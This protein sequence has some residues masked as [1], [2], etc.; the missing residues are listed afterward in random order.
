MKLF[1][2]TIVAAAIAASVFLVAA[3]GVRKP[4]AAESAPA[5]GGPGPASNMQLPPEIADAI[6]RREQAELATIRERWMA[7]EDRTEIERELRELA[8]N[9]SRYGAW[10]AS[11]HE[12]QGNERAAFEAYRKYVDGPEYDSGDKR[13]GA[14]YAKMGAWAERFGTKDE[15][16]FYWRKAAGQQ[17]EGGGGSL[18]VTWDENNLDHLKAAYHLHRLAT[19]DASTTGRPGYPMI[20]EALRHR[21]DWPILWYELA[22]LMERD[23]TR[24][25]ADA[26]RAYDVAI[27]LTSGKDRESLQ[28]HSANQREFV[29]RLRAGEATEGRE[30]TAVPFEVLLKDVRIPTDAR[31]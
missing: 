24:A 27:S 5:I 21:P 16:L 4:R 2:L 30:I 12:A 28:R 1:V 7:A 14:P 9:D 8:G 26:V 11:F 15:V 3:Q 23:T 31:P 6:L 25:T 17:Q 10:L 19:V 20:I 29:R 13:L 18:P 22:T